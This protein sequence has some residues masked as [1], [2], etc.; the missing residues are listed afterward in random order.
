LRCTM[1]ALRL[2]AASVR[3]AFEPRGANA[4]VFGRRPDHAAAIE[5]LA[6]PVSEY[7]GPVDTW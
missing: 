3:P 7:F 6:G 4:E 5:R 2:D 1:A